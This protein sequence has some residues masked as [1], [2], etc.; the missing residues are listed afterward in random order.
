MVD[1]GKKKIQEEIRK[2]REEIN[3]HDYLYYVLAQPK[4]DDYKYDI[5]LKKLEELEK[6]YPDFITHD[7]PTQRVGGQPT[8]VF[9]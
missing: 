4:I 7:S 1:V 9:Q 5:L 6:K 3:H 2:L 8:K